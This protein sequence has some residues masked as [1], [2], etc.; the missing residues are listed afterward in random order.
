MTQQL[1]ATIPASLAAMVDSY[2]DL[3]PGVAWDDSVVDAMLA[4]AA[5]NA[6]SCTFHVHVAVPQHGDAEVEVAI[7]SQLCKC[8]HSPARAVVSIYWSIPDTTVWE[9][10]RPATK[11]GLLEL[12]LET[13]R[14]IRCIQHGPCAQCLAKTPPDY[15][16][17]LT[18]AG[19]CLSCVLASFFTT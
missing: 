7:H 8:R 18:P 11:D 16:L 10:T 2:N 13:R 12:L 1:P 15:S 5:A 3:V 6:S 14:I 19:S 17:R 4:Q 9:G